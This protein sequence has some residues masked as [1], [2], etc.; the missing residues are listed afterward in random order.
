MPRRFRRKRKSKFVTKRALPFLL[1][2]NAEAKYFDDPLGGAGI[3]I[4]DNAPHDSELTLIST[5]GNVSSREGNEIQITGFYMSFTC[6][7]HVLAVADN[8]IHYIR[9]VLYSKRS[10]TIGDL[11]VTPTEIISKENYVVWVDKIA[12]VPL[13]SSGINAIMKIRKKWKPYMKATFNG[14]GS[15]TIVK[16]AVFLSITSD[17][18]NPL[19]SEFSYAARLFFRDL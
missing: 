1:A 9:V 18:P 3:L 19:L 12:Q 11:D 4:T 15:D 13:Q 17:A 8:D 14:T 10:L 5:G 2:K 6:A 7:P 16:N